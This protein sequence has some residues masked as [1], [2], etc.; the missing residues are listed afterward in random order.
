MTGAAGIAEALAGRRVK[1]HGG[2]YLVPCPAHDDANPSLSIRDGD[3]GLLVCCFAGCDPGDV[4][5]ALRRRGLLPPKRSSWREPL[6]LWREAID[7]HR[8][9][10]ERYLLRRGLALPPGAE[11]LRFHPACPFAGSKTPA[12]VALVRNIESNE[13]QA[14]HRTALDLGGSKITIDGKD[15]MALGPISGGA[16]KLTPD[17]DVTIAIGIAEG[18]ETALSLKRLPEWADS[19]VW[20]LISANGIRKF[21]L[22][23]GI[24]T[25]AIAADH[26]AAGER[27]AIEVAERWQ[28]REVLIFEAK[29]AGVD[30]NDIVREVSWVI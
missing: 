26:D 24:E 11:A 8:T 19:P 28:N 12:M 3:A 17:E 14:I 5:A 29:S 23:S 15:R 2:N 27:S 10:V 4:I 9:P 18:I 21:P 16:V 25:L 22:L 30:L 6:D 1:A 7:A 13:P 20:S